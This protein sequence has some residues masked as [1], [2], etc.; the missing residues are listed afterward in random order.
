MKNLIYCLL[1]PPGSYIGIYV[2]IL[3]Y[4]Y[5]GYW[6]NLRDKKDSITWEVLPIVAFKDVLLELDGSGLWWGDM[7]TSQK[8]RVF[9]YL[10][11]KIKQLFCKLAPCNTFKLIAHC[12][13]Y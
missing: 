13:I 7:D 5:S 8:T 12:N 2:V 10:T 4:I 9:L 11:N 3:P 6:R 1:L